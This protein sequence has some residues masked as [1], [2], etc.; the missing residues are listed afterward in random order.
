MTRTLN[1]PRG[2]PTY[3]VSGEQTFQAPEWANSDISVSI[4]FIQSPEGVAPCGVWFKA[5]VTG[6]NL[7]KR[8]SGRVYDPHFHDLHYTWTFSDPGDFETA[9]RL[10]DEWQG[11]NKTFG[12]FCSHVFEN[13]GTYEVT[14]VVRNKVGIIGQASVNISVSDPAVFF[15]GDRTIVVSNTGNFSG[16]PAGAQQAAS[17]LA[18]RSLAQAAGQKVRILL[19]RGENYWSEGR[20]K[21]DGTGLRNVYINAYG[22]GPKPVVAGIWTQQAVAGSGMVVANVETDGKWDPTTEIWQHTMAKTGGPNS[23]LYQYAIQQ[24][25]TI[26]R[27]K[28]RGDGATIYPAGP[29]QQGT[30]IAVQDCDI[31]DWQNFGV[32]ISA[33]VR[34]GFRGTLLHQNPLA[35]G[36]GKNKTGNHNQHGPIR[37][38]DSG[39]EAFLFMD[40]VSMFSNTGWS[41]FSNSELGSVPAHQSCFRTS[42][43]V[44]AHYVM[45]GRI[46]MEGGANQINLTQTA[47]GASTKPQNSLVDKALLIGTAA[48][49]SH[50]GVT[51]GGATLRNIV[52][53]QPDVRPM[54]T[55]GGSWSRALSVNN[56]GGDPAENGAELVSVYN[57]TAVSQLSAAR[58]GSAKSSL[59]GVAQAA[60]RSYAGNNVEHA[61]DHATPI[62]GGAF[63]T[64]DPL[65]PPLFVSHQWETAPTPDTSFATPVDAIKLPI[66]AAGNPAIGGADPSGLTAI[67]DFFGRIRPVKGK[68]RGAIDVNAV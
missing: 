24:F 11:R 15:S 25:L 10:P 13:A 57:C 5:N 20:V 59:I 66:P 49:T 6:S 7:P 36:G 48:S 40:Q 12:Q 31:R 47:A 43:G 27:C 56:G 46:V 62:N 16:A 67:D 23:G 14:C 29:V 38:S 65:F 21:F 52:T 63:E 9:V 61:P 51:L 1:F 32:L 30:V 58:S 50:A 19:R 64:V 39:L 2:T 35:L 54:K 68:S 34:A 42:G 33:A 22:S 53:I 17:F 37:W 41:G 45:M 4:D 55:G 18:A 8:E 44:P 26:F 28:G 60:M 3:M